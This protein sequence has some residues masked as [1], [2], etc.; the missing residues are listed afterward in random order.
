MTAT[1]DRPKTAV[2]MLMGDATHTSVELLGGPL[3]GKKISNGSGY[4]PNPVEVYIISKAAYRPA[5]VEGSVL[6]MVYDP[7]KTAWYSKLSAQKGA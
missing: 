2:E 6:L 5:R 1:L 3:D 7:V 4:I